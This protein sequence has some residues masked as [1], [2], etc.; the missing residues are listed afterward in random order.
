MLPDGSYCS[1]KDKRAF[2]TTPETGKIPQPLGQPVVVR[3]ETA[4][5]PTKRVRQDGKPL[6][7]KLEAQYFNLL[8]VRN[9]GNKTLRA[10][11]KKFRLANGAFYKPDFTAVVDGKEHAWEVKGGK[12]M[13]DASRGVLIIKVVATLWPEITWTFV[14]K[15][16]GRWNEQLILP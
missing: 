10:Q 12:R 2:R 11:A 3:P 14:T 6:M 9:P 7:N 1:P 4:Q 16:N 15:E 8:S 13:K 5:T